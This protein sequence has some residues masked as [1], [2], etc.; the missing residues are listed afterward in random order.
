MGKNEEDRAPARN[1]L[2]AQS[3]HALQSLCK[4]S[5]K[6]IKVGMEP[7]QAIVAGSIEPEEVVKKLKKKTG[8][9]T[10]IISIHNVNETVEADES[11]NAETDTQVPFDSYSDQGNYVTEMFSNENPNSCSI[12]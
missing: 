4:D 3:V 12:L 11:E 6:S 7:N 1:C 2:G 8:K 9:R 10:E 5:V